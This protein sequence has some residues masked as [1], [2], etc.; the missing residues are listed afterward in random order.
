MICSLHLKKEN[1]ITLILLVTE[2]CVSLRGG[3]FVIFLVSFSGG[4]RKLFKKKK[5]NHATKCQTRTLK[6]IK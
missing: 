1:D 5:K 2:D 6:Q 4:T 3:F